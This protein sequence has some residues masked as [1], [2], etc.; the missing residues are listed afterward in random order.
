MVIVCYS[1]NGRFR[2]CLISVLANISVAFSCCYWNIHIYC[3]H[4]LWK[5]RRW[6]IQRWSHNRC[7][8]CRVQTL[9]TQFTYSHCSYHSLTSRRICCLLLKRSIDRLGPPRL[10]KTYRHRCLQNYLACFRRR[11]HVYFLM[12]WSYSPYQIQK[13][14]LK[15][16][17]C[18]EQFNLCFDLIRYCVHGF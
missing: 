12:D 18:P 16:R 10:T 13:H 1:S 11:S 8:H 9:E 7:L 4:Y 2:R 6:P 5:S 15:L 17:W 3:L 14:C